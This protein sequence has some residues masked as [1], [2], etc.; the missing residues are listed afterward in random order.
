MEKPESGPRG[1]R[2]CAE[3]VNTLWQRSDGHI[4]THFA[5]GRRAMEALAIAL[6]INPKTDDEYAKAFSA[7]QP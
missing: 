4:V 5:S 6:S 2:E 7:P 3:I 1:L